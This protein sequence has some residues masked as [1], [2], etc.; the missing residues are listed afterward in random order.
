MEGLH[1]RALARDLGLSATF[2]LLMPF[3]ANFLASLGCGGV[4]VAWIV[5]NC[6]SRLSA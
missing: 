4:V 5:I 6:F 3:A 1:A 2:R